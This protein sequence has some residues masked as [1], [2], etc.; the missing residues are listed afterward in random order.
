M[1]KSRLGGKIDQQ[2]AFGI[3]KPFKRPI[4]HGRNDWV[5]A[6][7]DDP[8]NRKR[9]PIFENPDGLKGEQGSQIGEKIKWKYSSEYRR[10]KGR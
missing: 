1:N 8:K 3:G 5:V 6:Q 7:E 4:K 9:I 2:A 10:T